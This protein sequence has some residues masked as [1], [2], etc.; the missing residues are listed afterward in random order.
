LD[1]P[2]VAAYLFEGSPIAVG[3]DSLSSSPSLDVM[4]DVA[5]LHTIA[6]SQ[7]YTSRDLPEQLLRAATLGGAHAMGIDVGPKR[8]G[9]LAVGALADL[10]FFDIPVASVEDTLAALVEHGT[11]RAAATVIA[12]RLRAASGEYT[13]QTGASARE[14]LVTITPER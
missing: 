11:G 10:A 9:Y 8:T 14:E 13:A 5:A 3:T 7:G 12:G 2:P 4:A 6:R 1:E